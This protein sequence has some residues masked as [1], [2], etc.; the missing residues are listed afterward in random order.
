ML[1][2]NI[3]HANWKHLSPHAVKYL[4][5]NRVSHRL[6]ML[7]IMCTFCNCINNFSENPLSYFVILKMT[8]RSLLENPPISQFAYSSKRVHTAPHD[9]VWH[10]IDY[11]KSKLSNCVISEN[12]K[13]QYK[14][15][16]GSISS[17]MEG[18]TDADLDN[19]FIVSGYCISLA[20][21]FITQNLLLFCL[22][23]CVNL[24]A[25]S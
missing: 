17:D 3:W 22:F 24:C 5:R 14:M 10:K 20:N 6:R 18:E 21:E 16:R 4:K 23:Q 9:Y 15:P 8:H 13:A 1:I 11:W 25:F 19:S 2:G 12:S 7:K